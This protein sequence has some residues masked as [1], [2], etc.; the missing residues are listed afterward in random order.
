MGVGND[1][2]TDDGP[3]AVK[4]DDKT[5]EQSRG[6]SART[7]G[8][9]AVYYAAAVIALGINHWL[10][11]KATSSS[12]LIVVLVLAPFLANRVS[13]FSIGNF[14]VQL[15]EVKDEL[16]K[17]NKQVRQEISNVSRNVDDRLA[18]LINQTK[19][20]LMPQSLAISNQKAD[21]MRRTINLSAEEVVAGLSSF[22]PDLRV[23]A[24][25]QLQVRPD[26]QYIAQLSSCFWLESYLA[27]SRKETRPLFQLLLA[28][29]DC[30]SHLN[31]E[32]LKKR[33]GL[34]MRHCL[35]YLDSDTTVDQGGQC[36]QHLR[37]LLADLRPST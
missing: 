2:E 36:K 32:S 14:S 5:S 13:N 1:T 16:R 8:I 23:P 25:I 12:V 31:D 3:D 7:L 29:R 27:S 11:F 30:S 15:R 28:V 20:Y 10:P 24:Y 6:F 9:L 19:D 37:Q 4:A 35:E 34:S 33:L 18:E 26:P 22:N 21:E 17:S